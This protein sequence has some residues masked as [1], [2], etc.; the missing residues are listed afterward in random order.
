[1]TLLFYR[2]SCL[3]VCDN[4]YNMYK[5][6]LQ[7]RTKLIH[8]VTK[9]S[10]FIRLQKLAYS[11]GYEIERHY[12]LTPTYSHYLAE[13]YLWIINNIVSQD[14]KCSNRILV[15]YFTAK[16]VYYTVTVTISKWQ[17]L[18]VHITGPTY[19]DNNWHYIWITTLTMI[20][21]L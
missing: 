6:I 14:M 16:R 18:K 19:H 20:E 3:F 4:I 12:K 9:L 1:M 21:R 2:H 17:Y 15:Y 5:C 7:V 13:G 11:Y 8:T 10:L